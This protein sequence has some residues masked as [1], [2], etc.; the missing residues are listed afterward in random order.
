MKKAWLAGCML[1]AGLV[2]LHD[3]AAA[4]AGSLLLRPARVWTEGAPVH[5]GWVVA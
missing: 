5:T 3:A 2:T 1:A 4:D